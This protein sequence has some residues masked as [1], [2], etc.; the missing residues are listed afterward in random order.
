MA[1][2]VR[3]RT[4]EIGVRVALG[5]A[6]ADVRLLILR[7]GLVLVLLGAVAGGLTSLAIGQALASQLYGVAPI[8]PVSIAAAL[9]VLSVVAVAAVWIPARRATRID[10]IVA[11]RE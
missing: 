8:D 7:Q 2:S 6:I 9:G 10:P 1:F 3:R 5:A 4:R 11:L